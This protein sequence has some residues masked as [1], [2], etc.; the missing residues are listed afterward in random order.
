QPPSARASGHGTAQTGRTQDCTRPS[1]VTVKKFLAIRKP[2][3]ED[4]RITEFSALGPGEKRGLTAASKF[5]SRRRDQP[6]VGPKV[7]EVEDIGV[8]EFGDD[9]GTFH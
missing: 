6:P 9:F 3:T 1:P 8:Q 7:A 4:I 2:S 5:S